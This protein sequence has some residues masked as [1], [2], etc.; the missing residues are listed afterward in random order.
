M[1]SETAFYHAHQIVEYVLLSVES[2]FQVLH[3]VFASSAKDNFIV[4][5]LRFCAVAL[6]I[7]LVA[8]VIRLFYS[9]LLFVSK[10]VLLDFILFF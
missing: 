2:S 3:S 9:W 7:P 4:V 5:L 8:L 1:L 10:S 6:P